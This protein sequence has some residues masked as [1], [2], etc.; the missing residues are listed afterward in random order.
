MSERSDEKDAKKE[1][2]KDL[3]QQLHAGVSPDEVKE[4]FKAVL[5]NIGPTEIAQVEEE[6]VNQGLPRQEIQKL[7]EVHLAIFR[8]SLEKPRS[9]VPSGHPI[10]I[11]LKE[12]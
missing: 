8:E 12:H 6:L 10:H 1:M 11:L 7:C 2:I 3:I 4:R 9:E 5:K